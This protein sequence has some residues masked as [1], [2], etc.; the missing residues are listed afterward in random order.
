MPV[1]DHNNSNETEWINTASRLWE[2]LIHLLSE[3]N[4]LYNHLMADSL[5]QQYKKFLGEID[6]KLHLAE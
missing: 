2:I 3:L 1:I 4:M 6:F 5:E